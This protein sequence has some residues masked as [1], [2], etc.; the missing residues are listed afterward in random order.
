MRDWIA[1][2]GITRDEGFQISL[3]S[4]FNRLALAAGRI[5]T[6]VRDND[7]GIIVVIDNTSA[8]AIDTQPDG[9]YGRSPSAGWLGDR[10]SR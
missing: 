1:V 8:V 4:R 3:C 9:P 10:I 2:N 6:R 5:R 7:D